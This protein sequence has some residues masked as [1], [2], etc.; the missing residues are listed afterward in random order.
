MNQRP[1]AE[2][3][4]QNKQVIADVLVRVFTKTAKV[5]ELGAGTGQ[6]AR[7]FASLFTHLHW[8]PTEM[9]EQM[10]T[11]ELGVAESGFPNLD[12]A[13]PVNVSDDTTHPNKEMP[14]EYIY[15]ANTMHIMPWQSVLDMISMIGKAL[16]PGGIF[17]SYGPYNQNGK[18]TS[19]SNKRFDQ[20]L[21]ARGVGS[22]LRDIDDIKFECNAVGLELSEIVEMPVNNKILVWTMQ[23]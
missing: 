18:F 21:K 16:S 14:F 23:E 3:A 1:Y 17:A 10:S 11:L 7:Y 6:H 20:I 15:T 4:D 8:T 2:S 9:A 5:L 22:G 12:E 19:E 13:I